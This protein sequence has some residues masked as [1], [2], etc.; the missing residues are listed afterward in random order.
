[1]LGDYVERAIPQSR[2]PRS[3]WLRLGTRDGNDA[4]IPFNEGRLAT[5]GTFAK[6]SRDDITERSPM[7]KPKLIYFDAS[8]SR[9]EECR[10]ALA[11][12][13]F[14]A[15]TRQ[16]EHC[17]ASKRLFDREEERAFGIR[18]DASQ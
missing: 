8:V 15:W 2:L 12:G 6:L 7:A 16:R 3:Q 10:L 13:R 5:N 17:G 1:M 9:G 11:S 18:R 14:L 4:R